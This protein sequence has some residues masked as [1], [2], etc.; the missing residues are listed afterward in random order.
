MARRTL[1]NKLA[2]RTDEAQRRIADLIERSALSIRGYNAWGQFLDAPRRTS[3]YGLY[4][5][6]AAVQVLA[7]S[8]YS[9][10]SPLVSRALAAI[11]GLTSST[12]SSPLYDE[13]DLSLTFKETAIIDACQPNKT[14]F[15]YTEPIEEIL[16]NQLIDGRGWG[17]YCKGPDQDDTPKLLPTAH[18]LLSLR[19]SRQF[20]DSERCEAVLRWF[21]E[22]IIGMMEL[23]S[24]YE[25]CMALLVLV[26]YEPEAK[27]LS[28]Y[29]RAHE[30][31]TEKVCHWI[32]HLNATLIGE[33]A[34]Y[35]Y[36]VFSKNQQ[37]NHYMY[38]P[39]DLLA[40]LALL[41]AGNPKSSR[42]KV[43]WVVNVLC[44][45]VFA[46]GGYRSKSSNRL[47]TV[48]QMWAYDLLGAF[49]QAATDK[50]GDILSPI[51]YALSGTQMRSILMAAA[52][53]VLGAAG[54][55]ISTLNWLN[56]ELRVLGAVM[57]TVALGVLTSAIFV[58]VRG[59]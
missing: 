2:R 18:A 23:T 31:L 41:R 1:A 20:R 57:S 22:V 45:M 48:D 32:K 33:T 12:Q 58:W 54:T 35:H 17:N 15:V 59:D 24:I 8:G 5:T 19:R 43:K 14:N 10:E 21:T 42:M 53:F 7:A 3:Q 39:V 30:L 47:A 34:S 51:A 4:G 40:A 46:E 38:Y 25:A 11:P 49:K 50:P 6:S 27:R 28:A 26:E 55:A 29:D 56:L 44:N 52:A 36:Y 13:F 9:G 16:L 37:H